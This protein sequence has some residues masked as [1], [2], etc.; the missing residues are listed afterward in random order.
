MTPSTPLL[1]TAVAV[2]ATLLVSVVEAASQTKAIA[3]FLGFEG[4]ALLAAVL[5]NTLLFPPAGSD[6][7]EWL[8]VPQ[9]RTVGF[10]LKQPLFYLGVIFLVFQHAL[11]GA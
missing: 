7:W 3:L 9:R 6:L 11:N 10:L 1:F 4:I 5:L 2:S 8:F